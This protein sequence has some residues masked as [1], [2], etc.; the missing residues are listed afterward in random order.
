MTGTA[1]ITP[2]HLAEIALALESAV[3]DWEQGKAPSPDTRDYVLIAERVLTDRIGPEYLW[4]S[5]AT[6]ESVA[7]AL[8]E[9][10]CDGRIDVY[11]EMAEWLA[12][13][14]TVGTEVA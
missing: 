3:L 1:G 12:T 11:P 8:W 7:E 14:I 2:E 5:D 13:A 10:L 6:H 4:L 9:A